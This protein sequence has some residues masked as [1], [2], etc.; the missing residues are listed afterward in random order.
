MVRRYGT[1]GLEAFKLLRC[2]L[3]KILQEIHH[4]FST[5][6]KH[7]LDGHLQLRSNMKD[8]ALN[9]KEY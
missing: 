5:L 1:F 7:F 3:G 8:A 2:C 6:T 9:K 4:L